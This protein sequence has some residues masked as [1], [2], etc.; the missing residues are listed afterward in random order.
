MSKPIKIYD[1]LNFML[2]FIWVDQTGNPAR[3]FL[4]MLYEKSQS[5]LLVFALEGPNGVANRRKIYPNYKAT[6]SYKDK[7][8]VWP[9][10]SLMEKMLDLNGLVSFRHPDYEGDDVIWSLVMS[11]P[12]E[13]PIHIHSTDWDLFSCAADN[14]TFDFKPPNVNPYMM[15]LYKTFVGDPPDSIPGLPG[16]GAKLWER[17]PVSELLDLLSDIK[18]GTELRIPTSFSKRH[19][20]WLD[21][22]ENQELL[23]TY[24]RVVTPNKIENL[25]Q[26]AKVGKTPYNDLLAMVEKATNP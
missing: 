16:F 24:L 21:R 25:D 8:E 23:L 14:V 3:S 19:R 5:N 12:P 11:I 17:T 26:Y 2:S 1:S 22:R 6:R 7:E 18:A 10:I 9:T 13:T 20:D 15:D 4:D